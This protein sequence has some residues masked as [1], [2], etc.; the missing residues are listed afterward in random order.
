M[1]M[2]PCSVTAKGCRILVCGEERLSNEKKLRVVFQNFEEVTDQH[3]GKDAIKA[4][5]HSHYYISLLPTHRE[6]PVGV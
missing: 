2:L 5:K 6:T 1:S 3:A 4:S